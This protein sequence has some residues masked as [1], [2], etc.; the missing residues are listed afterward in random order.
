MATETFKPGRQ[1]SLYHSSADASTA[2]EVEIY[3]LDGDHFGERLG[4]GPGMNMA[5]DSIV[6]SIAATGDAYVFS[7]MV[8]Q[9][10]GIT[11]A[12]TSA[13][14][15]TVLGDW[16]DL[17]KAGDTFS[18]NGSTGNDAVW[19]V[20]SVAFNPG[21]GTGGV[22]TTVITV[23]GN[24]TNATGDGVI[25]LRYYPI[26]DADNSGGTFAFAGDHRQMF[27]VGRLFKVEGST[28]NDNSGNAYTVTAV[29]Y[30]AATGRTT[31]TV[32]SVA[33]GTDDGR[34][35]PQP[36]ALSGCFLWRGNP[37]N[38]TE[39]GLAMPY[40]VDLPEGHGLF[41]LAAAGS[42]DLTGTGWWRL[43]P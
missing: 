26:L 33:N 25:A 14:T 8:G 28:G 39:V 27:R 37:A 10:I 40:E 4:V 43:R 31:V 2:K 38:N 6:L 41:V 15:L 24:I 23:T 13:E 3:R 1:V 17:I 42:I 30:S 18:V 7:D 9:A 20:L 36:T 19:T 11:A 16:T 22:G 35:I 32:A 34:I 29:S 21:S 5:V 12:S